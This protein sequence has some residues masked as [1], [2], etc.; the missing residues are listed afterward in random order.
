MIRAKVTLFLKKLKRKDT[1]TLPIEQLELV[2]ADELTRT[3]KN[4]TFLDNLGRC[5]WLR[6]E[7]EDTDLTTCAKFRCDL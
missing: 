4:C 7:I 1:A 5:F 3:C 2:I 6:K